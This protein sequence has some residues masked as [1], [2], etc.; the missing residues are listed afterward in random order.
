MNKIRRNQIQQ[1]IQ[2][3]EE[4]R[5]DLQDIL[6]EEYEA[7]DNMPDGLKYSE[8]GETSEDAQANMES[9]ID[10]LEE[11]MSYLEEIV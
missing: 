6:N 3:I 11:A 7:Y 8:R 2:Q 4:I 5:N 1:T 10:S 9:A